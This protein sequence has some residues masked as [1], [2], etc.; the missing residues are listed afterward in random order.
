MPAAPVLADPAPF[1]TEAVP[2]EVDDDG[3]NSAA[4][5]RLLTSLGDSQRTET[6]AFSQSPPQSQPL[7]AAAIMTPQVAPASIAPALIAP[8]LAAP[9]APASAAET[10]PIAVGPL[11]SGFAL[12]QRPA[13]AAVPGMALPAQFCSAEARNQFHDGPYIAAVEAAKRN[14]DAAI[15]YM[16]QLQALY[17]SNQLRGDIN[18]MNALAAEARAFAPVAAS[19]F[20]A[21]SALVSAFNDLM[22]VPISPCEPQQ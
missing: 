20:A 3:E 5:R 9:A 12:P 6:P 17:D 19:T 18:P 21:Q 14:N 8:L 15:A 4:L 1:V 2:T 16:R 22:A 7:A 11:P 13:L 10:H